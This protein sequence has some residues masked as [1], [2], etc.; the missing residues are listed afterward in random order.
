M[1]LENWWAK[2]KMH[3]VGRGPPFSCMAVKAGTI[4]SIRVISSSHSVARARPS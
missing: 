4:S 2:R 3:S 1:S